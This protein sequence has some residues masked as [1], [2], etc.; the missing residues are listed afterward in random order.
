MKAFCSHA[1]FEVRGLKADSYAR[2]GYLVRFLE[3]S[4][5]E[6]REGWR[7]DFFGVRKEVLAA[8]NFFRDG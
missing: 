8:K 7:G 3:F 6:N 1:C 4:A 2:F 5:V